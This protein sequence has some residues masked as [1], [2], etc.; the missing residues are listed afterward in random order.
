[1]WYDLAT[2][3]PSCEF[4]KG[5]GKHAGYLASLWTSASDDLGA[6]YVTGQLY[7]TEGIDYWPGPLDAAGECSYATSEKWARIWKIS[8]TDII[9]FKAL[10]SRTVSTVPV[11]ILEWPAKGNIY[12]K[13][14]GKAMLSISEEMAPFVDVDAD[15]IY[16]PIKG[17]YP[18]I[19]GD[20]MLWWIFND[21]GAT[22]TSS[23]GTP[24]KLEYKT[25]AYAYSR[26][27]EID[28]VVYYEFNMT[29]KSKIR[30][31]DFRFGLFSDADLGNPFDDY[32]AFDSAHRMGIM[33]NGQ[34]PDLNGKKSYG[35]HP[36]VVGI[37]FINMPGDK[38]PHAMMPAGA[39]NYFE[40]GLV[41]PLRDPR[42]AVEFKNYMHAKD[43]DGIPRYF[44]NYAFE[45]KKGAVQCDSTYPFKDRRFVIA[46]GNYNFQPNTNTIVAMALM[47]TDTTGNACP[48]IDFKPITDLADEAWEVF[49]NPKPPLGV[50]EIQSLDKMLRVYPNPA[51]NYL[52]ID[53]YTGK[54]LKAE[55]I[56]VFDMAGK[57]IKIA[58]MQNNKQI[59]IET[60]ALTSGTYTLTYSENGLIASQQFTK[61]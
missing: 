17:D 36:P 50:K 51:S 11:D 35:M 41:G 39:F 19:K 1:M 48:K 44:G 24:L 16:D 49:Y 58:A 23:K 46:T 43:A 14:A 8:Q 42:A 20:Q 40:N 26:G 34:L 57:E 28:N 12:A 61:R 59:K 30:Y 45:I 22:H 33:Y 56:K 6:D 18:Q 29:N 60:S 5:S 25:S 53:S 55:M 7:R 21:N 32:I 13:G 15:G 9:A 52:F 4:P 31:V 2:G 3:S 47:A 37:S 38:Y 10:S 27:T 54:E